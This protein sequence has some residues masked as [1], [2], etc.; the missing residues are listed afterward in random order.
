MSL[1]FENYT[2]RNP[3]FRLRG[4]WDALFVVCFLVTLSVSAFAQNEEKSLPDKLI[5][6]HTTDILPTQFVDEEGRSSGYLI[7]LWKLWSEKVGVEVE[8][9]PHIWEESVRVV[10]DGE[11]DIHSGRHCQTNWPGAEEAIIE[12]SQGAS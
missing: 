10:R 5:I 1:R 7:D 2:K 3:R 8:F 6:S 11:A 9:H 12:D 4:L